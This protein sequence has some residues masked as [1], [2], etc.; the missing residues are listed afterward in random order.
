MPIPSAANDVVDRWILGL[1]LELAANFLGACYE[2]GW[3]TVTPRRQ[4]VDVT[5]E[6]SIHLCPHGWWASRLEERLPLGSMFG[7]DKLNH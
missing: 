4:G 7:R 5:T 6:E 3:V 2:D 1:P